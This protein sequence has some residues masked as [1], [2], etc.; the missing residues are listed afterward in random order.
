L[1]A[2]G[3]LAVAGGGALIAGPLLTGLDPKSDVYPAIVWMLVIWT[4]FH[5]AVGAIMQLY[6][7]ARRAAGRMTARHDIDIRNVAL[8][9]HFTIIT[10]LVTVA[11]IAGFPLVK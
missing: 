11:V 2:G 5:V 3:A 4:A 10:V 8:Y 1:L 6:C 7:L 9:W